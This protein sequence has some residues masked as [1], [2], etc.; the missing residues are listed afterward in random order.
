MKFLCGICGEVFTD[1]SEC[2]AHEV[3]HRNDIIWRQVH[4]RRESGRWGFTFSD[5]RKGYLSSDVPTDDRI[6]RSS[7]DDK[8]WP[9]WWA[10][11]R[12]TKDAINATKRKLMD[13][14]MQWYR[15]QAGEIEKM[16]EDK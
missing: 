10:A 5:I 12:N 7:A 1:M 4:L 6:H 9:V 16:E 11:C 2:A 14:A 3:E 13:A 15:E 8:D